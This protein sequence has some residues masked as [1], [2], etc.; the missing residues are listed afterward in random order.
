MGS[1]KFRELA[2]DGANGEHKPMF[3]N[4]SLKDKGIR[5]AISKLS[6]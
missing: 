1:L 4:K 3:L 2:P 5:R 6:H